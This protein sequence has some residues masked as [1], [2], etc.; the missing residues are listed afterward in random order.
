VIINGSEHQ[1]RDIETGLNGD[2]VTIRTGKADIT[3]R[4]T[5]KQAR[6]LSDELRRLARLAESNGRVLS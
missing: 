2:F 1:T 4:I 6:R 5:P 3:V